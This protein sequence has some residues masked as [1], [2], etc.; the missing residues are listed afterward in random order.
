VV[1]LLADGQGNG[2]TVAWRRK[3]AS[4]E[5]GVGARGIFEAIEVE[6]EFAGFVE[7]S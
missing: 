5:W 4:G 1:A 6:N 3:R 2:K 7:A